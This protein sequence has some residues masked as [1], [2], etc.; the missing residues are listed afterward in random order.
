MMVSADSSRRSESPEM[1]P[2]ID[3]LSGLKPYPVICMNPN[4]SVPLEYHL[5][6]HGAK[7]RAEAEEIL[8]NH[9]AGAYL[10]RDSTTKAS[11]VLD[12][13]L[14]TTFGHYLISYGDGM[15]TVGEGKFS[16][17]RET[18]MHALGVNE[19][20]G[21]GKRPATFHRSPLL[22]TENGHAKTSATAGSGGKVS[23]KRSFGMSRHS[24][25]SSVRWRTSSMSNLPEATRV[26]TTR[27]QVP[28]IPMER[29]FSHDSIVSSMRKESVSC[30]A[31]LPESTVHVFEHSTL[32]MP[33]HT[34]ASCKKAIRPLT[35]IGKC[36]LCNA[37]VHTTCEDSSPSICSPNWTVV[38]NLWSAP[39]SIA[40]RTSSHWV[41]VIVV[42][43]VTRVNGFVDRAEGLYRMS[44]LE[45][46]IVH[47]KDLANTDIRGALAYIDQIGNIHT[48]ASL[49][50]RYL[51]ELPGKLIPTE[52]FEKFAVAMEESSEYARHKK[53][54]KAMNDLPVGNYCTL[55]YVLE[56][57]RFVSNH[58]TANKMTTSALAMVFG[59]VFMDP[60]KTQ[61]VLSS[62][63]S[64]HSHVKL[65]QELI[66]SVPSDS[67]GI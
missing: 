55:M 14:G 31:F 2:N 52:Y 50:K 53:L 7:S 30:T 40:F 22:M 35:T 65:V 20:Q 46:D 47:V 11:K 42:A 62:L 8:S 43:C 54:Y 13:S 26:D 4:T 3:P 60:H 44:G 25:G 51:R 6:Y 34:C 48:V 63:N 37:I 59:P 21:K 19:T 17:I 28:Q 1:F 66:R 33:G 61:D 5:V 18:V 32:K 49:L 36:A 9:G 29:K 38:K 45:Q 16:T 10:V 56:H 58:C 27:I 15:Y 64:A 12:V 67:A 39:I 57:L 41:P 23:P 24:S